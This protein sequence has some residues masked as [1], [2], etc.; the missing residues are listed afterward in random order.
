V[1]CDD[2]G[3]CEPLESVCSNEWGQLD[4]LTYCVRQNTG[5]GKANHSIGRQDVCLRCHPPSYSNVFLQLAYNNNYNYRLYNEA[6][7]L[8]AHRYLYLTGIHILVI[9]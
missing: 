5:F 9:L 4:Y 3:I 2:H 8:K 6:L 7:C 1:K